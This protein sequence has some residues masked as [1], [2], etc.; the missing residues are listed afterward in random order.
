MSR[1]VNFFA[2]EISRFKFGG[3]NFFFGTS[4]YVFVDKQE[5]RILAGLDT[6]ALFCDVDSQSGDSLFVRVRLAGNV[7]KFG[8]KCYFAFLKSGKR[9]S[10]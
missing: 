8:L 10:L 6:A 5:V 4:E 2:L 7:D 3:V 1:R 9:P